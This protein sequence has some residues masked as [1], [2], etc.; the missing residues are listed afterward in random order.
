MYVAYPKTLKKWKINYANLDDWEKL[1]FINEYFALNPLFPKILFLICIFKC[2]TVR[3]LFQYLVL[4]AI[5]GFWRNFK[6]DI[7]D[8]GYF[9]MQ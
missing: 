8:Y 1:A 3:M 9:K 7:L 2:D 4:C 6:Q 5:K